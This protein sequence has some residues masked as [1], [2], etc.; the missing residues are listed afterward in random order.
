MIYY[1]FGSKAS[2]YAEV[3]KNLCRIRHLEIDLQTDDLEPPKLPCAFS[4]VRLSD[5]SNTTL[6][7]HAS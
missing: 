2:L 1:Y 4:F 3:L 5:T 7:P 6:R